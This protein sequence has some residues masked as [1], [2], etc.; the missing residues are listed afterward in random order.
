M[1]TK[2]IVLVLMTFLTMLLLM[3]CSDKDTVGFQLLQG[4]KTIMTASDYAEIKMREVKLDSG[5]LLFKNVAVSASKG[6]FYNSY[7]LNVTTNTAAEPEEY[8]LRVTM[9]GK[10]AQVLGGSVEGNTVTFNIKDLS[11]ENRLFLI[12]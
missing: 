9:P 11:R 5:T 3:G 2:W 10:V 6:L 4:G 1:K 8:E 7:T 12:K